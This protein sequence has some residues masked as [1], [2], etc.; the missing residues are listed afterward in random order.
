MLYLGEIC[1][2][3]THKYNEIASYFQKSSLDFKLLLEVN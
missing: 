1:L 2:L 3:I